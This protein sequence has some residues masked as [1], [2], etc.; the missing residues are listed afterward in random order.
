M[1]QMK[2]YWRH[3]GNE[4]WLVH[5]YVYNVYVFG[6]LTYSVKLYAHRISEIYKMFGNITIEAHRG[7]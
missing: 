4:S 2:E 5:D 1:F 3:E 6:Y 7:M